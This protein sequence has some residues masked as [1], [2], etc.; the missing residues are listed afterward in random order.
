MGKPRDLIRKINAIKGIFHT[1]MSIIKDRNG[2]DITEADDI[3]Q[4]Q[5]YTE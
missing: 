4:W 1:K 2:M 5:E 3:K